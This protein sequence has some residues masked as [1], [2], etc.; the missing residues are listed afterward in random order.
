MNLED[1]KL[2]SEYLYQ[3]IEK[4]QAEL[5]EH[6]KN[7]VG[8]NFIILRHPDR[9]MIVSFILSGAY[10]KGYIYKCIYSD[11]QEPRL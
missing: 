11:F 6:G 7:N 8:E 3:A 9:D 2:H 1:F 4:V 10:S 5:E